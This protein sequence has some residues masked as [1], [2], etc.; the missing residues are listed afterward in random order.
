MAPT[1]SS[2]IPSEIPLGL[3]QSLTVDASEDADNVALFLRYLGL[4][5]CDRNESDPP[6]SFPAWFLVELAAALRIWLWEANGLRIHLDA[7]LA[8]ARELLLGVFCRAKE[9]ANGHASSNATPLMN[10]VLGLSVDRLAWSARRDLGADV[11]LGEADEDILVE[12]LA[13]LIWTHRADFGR[14]LS[15]PGRG[16]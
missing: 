16:K 12:T 11:V 10:R 2:L 8:P 5:P 7:G 3:V 9:V 15:Q 4:A 13:N 6:I 1:S 14:E